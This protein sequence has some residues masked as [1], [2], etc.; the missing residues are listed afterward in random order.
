MNRTNILLILISSLLFLSCSSESRVDIV[1]N[2]SIKIIENINNEIYDDA[3]DL[4]D[5]ENINKKKHEALKTSIKNIRNLVYTPYGQNPKIGLVY[6]K[7]THTKSRTWSLSLSGKGSIDDDID[8]E[9]SIVNLSIEG[10][11]RYG[12]IQL[13]LDGS[14]NKVTSIE[15]GENYPIPSL[16]KFWLLG[17][18]PL[19]V[20]AFNVFVIYK[21]IKS[22]F[23]KKWLKILAV[24]ILNFP[25]IKIM[26]EGI[27]KL[28]YSLQ[29][30]FGASFSWWGY[31]YSYWEIGIPLGG[32]VMLIKL[33]RDKIKSL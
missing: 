23:R 18:F 1:K 4:F 14:N 29:Y 9:P 6:A 5:F 30:L 24:I 10:K 2:N 7:T 32:I 12:Y 17:L 15:V 13:Y 19:L 16:W 31:D 26:S 25:T 27:F 33:R 11:G 22:D 20:V 21:I 8:S 28:E 3:Y